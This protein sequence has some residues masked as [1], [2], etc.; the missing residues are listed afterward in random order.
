MRKRYLQNRSKKV[1]PNV[2]AF[3]AV[4]NACAL[5]VEE[6]EKED[7]FAIAQLT[8]SELLVGDMDKPNFLSF[9]AFL[10]AIS[11]TLDPS[12]ERD[13][14]V[15][16]AFKQCRDAGQVGQIVLEKLCTAAS[17]ELFC[18]LVGSCMDKAGEFQLPASWTASIKGE[19][20]PRTPRVYSVTRPIKLSRAS[21]LRLKA[22]QQ[23]GGQSGSFTGKQF[24]PHETEWI[25][26]SQKS[27]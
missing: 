13:K 23:F 14:I 24:P 8:M 2:V 9:A 15:E 5:P 10:S 27:L 20:N 25:Q 19:R 21:K 16:E 1:K 3:T 22:A 26:W 6:S 11:S 4:L 7:A 17:P 18:E 12:E